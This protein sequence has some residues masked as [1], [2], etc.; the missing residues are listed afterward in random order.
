[1]LYKWEAD[2]EFI[3]TVQGRGCEQNCNSIGGIF[4][5]DDGN[6][7]ILNALQK[8]CILVDLKYGDDI[9]GADA[10]YVSDVKVSG[11][12]FYM[13]N[14]ATY[15]AVTVDQLQD[16]TYEYIFP[17]I[18]LEIREIKDPYTA[19]LAE[20]E[21][22]STSLSFFLGLSMI[23]LAIAFLLVVMLAIYYELYISADSD[24]TL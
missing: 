9:S 18:P 20:G 22:Q 14:T 5:W 2:D 10:V 19:F 13:G 3:C 11:G 17:E 21:H 7:Y 4:S 6:C 24:D 8:L 12:C 16:R 15:E 1:M 23:S